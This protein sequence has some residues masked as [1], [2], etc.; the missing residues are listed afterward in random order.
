M[1]YLPVDVYVNARPGDC[2]NGG[3]TVRQPERLVVECAD[4]FMTAEDVANAGCTVLVV[5]DK[6]FAHAKPALKQ[7]FEKRWTMFG[8]NFVY[9]SDSRFPF[10]APV[11]VHD[12]IEG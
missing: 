11:A 6:P 8:G 2:T 5:K 3:I 1:R 4:G 7:E 12:R 9:S 10:D